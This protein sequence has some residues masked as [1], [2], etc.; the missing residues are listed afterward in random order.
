MNP[1]FPLPITRPKQARQAYT[2]FGP[3]NS[4]WPSGQLLFFA[5]GLRSASPTL[6]PFSRAKS[7]C[8]SSFH[9]KPS[10]RQTS[11]M[12]VSTSKN[13]ALVVSLTGYSLNPACLPLAR[14]LQQASSRPQHVLCPKQQLYELH[15]TDWSPSSYPTTSLLTHFPK[16]VH[17]CFSLNLFPRPHASQRLSPTSQPASTAPAAPYAYLTSLHR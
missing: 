17:L 9:A 4:Y 16:P 15:Y 2:A 13:L 7:A 8:F 3:A 5:Q 10:T 6:W 12:H 11:C 1:F 14:L